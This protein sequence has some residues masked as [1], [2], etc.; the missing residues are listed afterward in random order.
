MPDSL[1]PVVSSSNRCLP[2]CQW[3]WETEEATGTRTYVTYYKL[4]WAGRCYLPGD[5]FL[6]LELS[7]A[8]LCS[9]FLPGGD[10]RVHNSSERTCRVFVLSIFSLR[11]PPGDFQSTTTTKGN[12]GYI[13]TYLDISVGCV[14]R[15]QRYTGNRKHM[16]QYVRLASRKT[17]EVQEEYYCLDPLVR[18]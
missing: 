15:R 14:A 8:Y 13:D 1:A 17:P 11:D 10:V 16:Q 9:S 3:G 18:R 5:Y 2:L 7:R 12:L 4:V 6:N